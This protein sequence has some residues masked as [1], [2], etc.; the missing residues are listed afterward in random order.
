MVL[1]IRNIL[2]YSIVISTISS[3]DVTLNR[4]CTEGELFIVTE[5]QK[6]IG[7]D[8]RNCIQI[9][10][11]TMIASSL[12]LKS[13]LMTAGV[14]ELCASCYAATNAAY[15]NCL[16]ICRSSS[17]IPTANGSS[18]CSQCMRNFQRAYELTDDEMGT[19]QVF[20]ICRK[21]YADANGIIQTTGPP[22]T[23]TIPQFVIPSIERE[24]TR[25][26][27]EDSIVLSRYIIFPLILLLL[28]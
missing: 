17:V 19:G 20:T 27:K 8:L 22:V 26:I 13:C 24:S 11:A 10:P 21:G 6:E 12:S 5:L 4:I 14:T 7:Q 2:T 28:S 1:E 18:E 3:V 15:S 16:R 9:D 25:S 23:T